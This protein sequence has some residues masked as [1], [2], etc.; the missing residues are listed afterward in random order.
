MDVRTYRG[1]DVGSDH[2]LVVASI[3]LKLKVKTKENAVTRFDTLQLTNKEKRDEFVLECR[4]RFLT[5]EILKDDN[6]DEIEEEEEEDPNILWTSIRNV[7]QEAGKQVLGIR[8]AKKRKK[9][10]SDTTWNLIMQRRL[11]KQ[12]AERTRT[13]MEQ[14]A[15]WAIYWSLNKDVKRSARCDKRKYLEMLAAEADREMSSGRGKGVSAAYKIVKEIAGINNKGRRIPVKGKDGSILTTEADIKARC[16]EHFEEVMN[17][18]SVPTEDRIDT[19]VYLLQIWICRSG[20]R[21]SVKRK[22]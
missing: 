8:K 20:T 14:H 9:W 11:Q 5:L 16:R 6:S 13:E 12:R 3:Q 21:I 17:K 2:Q 18:P 4:N 1:A 19:S 7:Y 10:I 22:L 15:E